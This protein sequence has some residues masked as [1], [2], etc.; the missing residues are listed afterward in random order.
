MR[1][2]AGPDAIVTL[3]TVITL[4]CGV[5]ARDAPPPPPHDDGDDDDSAVP[6]LLWPL[7]LVFTVDRPQLPRKT[8]TICSIQLGT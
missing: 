8:R 4:A 5:R 2:R 1:A 3:V 7:V 6:C